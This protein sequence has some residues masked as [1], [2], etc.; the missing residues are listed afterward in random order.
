[1][2]KA[3]TPTT[4]QQ[5]REVPDGAVPGASFK[6]AMSG[7]SRIGPG[8]NPLLPNNDPRAVLVSSLPSL[9][10]HVLPVKVLR[11]LARALGQGD[12]ESA[13]WC[14]D[15]KTL[16]APYIHPYAMCA[17]CMLSLGLNVPWFA[18]PN[19]TL[20]ELQRK[21]ASMTE[22][23][24]LLRAQLASISPLGDSVTRLQQEM[25]QLQRQ[26]SAV[27][28][29]L[30]AAQH[31]AN[32]AN[33]QSLQAGADVNKVHQDVAVLRERT[34]GV[35][36]QAAAVQ[37]AVTTLQREATLEDI[38]SIV[39][40]LAS[41]VGE[42]R[43][44]KPKKQRVASPSRS[45]S[46]VAEDTAAEAAPLTLE[47]QLKKIEADNAALEAANV[48]MRDQTGSEVRGARMP[49]LP[50][51]PIYK[52][53]DDVEERLFVFETYLK[54]SNIPYHA[55]P[56]YIMPLLQD[57]ALTAWTNVAVPASLTNTPITW[58]MFKHT[59]LTAFAHPDRQLQARE[60]LHK[61]K[62]QHTQSATEY[63][64]HF[65]S[66]V[67]KAG[68]PTPSMYDLVLFFYNGL[69]P[70]LKE[71]VV[72]NPLTGKF[73]T[74]LQALQE[75]VVTLQTHA[76]SRAPTI[77]PKSSTASTLRAH[78]HSHKRHGVRVN[79]VQAQVASKPKPKR[80]IGKGGIGAGPSAPWAS[81]RAPPGS[82]EELNRRIK[83]GADRQ[84][85]LEQE[86]RELKAKM[87]K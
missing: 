65:Q 35:R 36:N 45:S 70:S 2:S 42:L 8:S 3:G 30:S 47:E 33:S 7:P 34:D 85:K 83:A 78:K 60:E 81:S 31:A 12:R 51:P 6:E 57:K 24:Q 48:A 39:R 5:G 77:V 50:K 64:R 62:Q 74:D 56:S 43:K 66:L 22:E 44:R 1:M 76:G 59:M 84:A 71:K 86:K 67:V 49:D 18:N 26:L 28:Q 15:H 17:L 82:L 10:K 55:W 69:T 19:H 54:A 63:V 87:K 11:H 16:I 52:G 79:A 32:V 68:S 20:Q 14:M 72:F 23:L 13:K 4:S 46:P 41:E 27:Q 9:D 75:H 21:H 53:G 58:D 73:W 25:A 38:L 37:Q 61:V 29:A 40:G 80:P